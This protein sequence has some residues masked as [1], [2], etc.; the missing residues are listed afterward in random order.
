MPKDANNS[1]TSRRQY[2]KYAS[3]GSAVALAGCLTGDSG[4]GSESIMIGATIPESG[5]YGNIGKNQVKG[6]ELAVKHANEDG[7]VS[8]TEVEVAFRDTKT[9]T[10]EATQVARELLRQENADFLA[11]NFSSSVA[12]AIGELAQRE[13]VI[14]TCVGGSNAITG[15]DCRSNVFNAGN[16]AVQQTSGGLKYALDEGL[17]ESVYEISADYSWG[18]SIQ[19]WNENQIVSSYDD[20]EYLGNSFVE[21]GATDY[22]QAIT[23]AR[24]SGADIISFNLF[25]S[26][27]VQSARQ[28]DEYDLFDDFVCVWPATGIIEAEQ[29]GSDILSR[30]NF[31]ASAPW[32]WQHEAEGAQAFSEAFQSEYGERPLGF[33]ASMYAG[34][35]TTLK[36]IDAAGGTE[37]ADI[38][39]Q[40]EDR[41]LF[42]QLWGVGEKFR[43]CDHR[44]SISTMTVQGRDPSDVDGQNFFEVINVPQNPEETQMRTCD[45]TGCSF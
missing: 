14:Y 25:A 31:Y 33:S 13:D 12:L 21:F 11:G 4:S 35:R 43:A 20:V 30:D 24:S 9:D 16:S 18:Q 8:D 39:D 10:Q 44:A 37:T 28:A 41:E 3:A 23:D 2:L 5:P 29:I 38:R 42:P 45:Q 36:A 19:A 34:V 40:M 6:V 27:H 32:Y 26:N 1:G 15:S 7:D 22:S 17:G